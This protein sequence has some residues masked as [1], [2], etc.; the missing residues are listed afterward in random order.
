MDLTLRECA[1][2]QGSSEA[3][4]SRG[5]KGLYGKIR[6]IPQNR[7]HE[8]LTRGIFKGIDGRAPKLRGP[9][10]EPK[11]PGSH[12]KDTHQKDIQFMETARQML[13]LRAVLFRGAGSVLLFAY[14]LPTLNNKQALS[15]PRCTPST[16]SLEG[17][18]PG[19]P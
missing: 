6:Q 11:C 12:H 10:I 9:D 8:A 1:L 7:C 15:G 2:F 16:A 3:S 18:C 17:S 13:S 5:V 19:K 14:F 4:S